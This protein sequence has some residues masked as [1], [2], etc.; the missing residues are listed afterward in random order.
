[1][2]EHFVRYAAEGTIDYLVVNVP[3]GDMTRDEAQR[4]LDAFV[5]EV[6]PGVRA[7][8]QPVR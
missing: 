2:R 4:T 7:A 6:M 5:E 1:V 3:F 8:A